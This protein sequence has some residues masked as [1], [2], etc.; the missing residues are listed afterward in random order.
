MVTNNDSQCITAQTMQTAVRCLTPG[1]FSAS[2]TLMTIDDN[3]IQVKFQVSNT[4]CI[5]YVAADII[6]PNYTWYC[7]SIW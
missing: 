5:S 6:A 7:N 4:A 2:L 3:F 1:P